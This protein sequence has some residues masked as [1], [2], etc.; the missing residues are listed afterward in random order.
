LGAGADAAAA[1]E[2]TSR[3]GGGAGGRSERP[4]AAAIQQRLD[5]ALALSNRVTALENK[6]APDVSTAVAPVAAQM[7]QLTARLD[8]I[9]ARLA[10][11]A[12][13]EAANAESPERVLMV[14]LASLGNA[15]ASSRPFAAE[16]ASVEALG[17]NRKGW[18]TALQPLEAAAKAGLPSAA[19]LAQRFSSDVAPAILRAEA[20]APSDQQSLGDAVLARL[21]GLIIIRRVDGGG[22]GTNPTDQ[23]V[24]Q[25]QA[26]LDKSD[27]AGAV[28]ALHALSG[29]AATAAQPWLTDAQTR[30][31][32]EQTI[33]QLGRDLAGDI[34]AA[35]GGG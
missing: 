14:A 32:A 12:H 3:G 1:V 30:L 16:L 22:T 7:Q 8:Q 33:A 28:Q 13:D 4:T 10:Q 17:Q 5:A 11:L 29:A 27:L 21:R 15:V 23:A 20:T 9:D 26:A 24:A 19:V 35:T 2:P 31:D 25:A 34:A 18:A 6:P